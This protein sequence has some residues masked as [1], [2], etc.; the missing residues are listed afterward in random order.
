MTAPFSSSIPRWKA[1]LAESLTT[2]GQLADRFGIAADKL[3]PVIKSFPMRINPYYLS[4]IREPGDPIWRQAVPDPL[5][6]NDAAGMADPLCEEATSPVPGLIHRYP[7][8]VVLLATEQCAMFCRFCMRKRRVGSMTWE[9]RLDATVDYLTRT[10]AVREV[11]LSGGD[12]FMLDDGVLARLLVRLRAIAHVRLLRIHSRMPCTLPQRVTDDLVRVLQDA[13]PLYLNIHFNHPGEITARVREACRRLADAG[14][15]LGSQTVLLKGVN[16]DPAVMHRLMETLLA[17]RV[18][19][20]YIHQ[21]DRVCGTAHFR[22][23][24]ERGLAILQHLRGRISGMGVPHYMIDLPGGGGKVPLI[25]AYIVEKQ[26]DH[27]VLRNFEGRTFHYPL[28]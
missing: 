9:D 25:P 4:L 16:D 11:V 27:W 2:A 28:R 14:I 8:R 13:Q 12:P 26:P 1:L 22:V 10:P 3:A 17:M 20:Y 6:L 23:P 19:P 5:E 7:D 21:L 24:V 18:R 15:P